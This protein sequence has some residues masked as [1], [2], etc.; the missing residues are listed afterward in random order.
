MRISPRF[1]LRIMLF[2]VAIAASASAIGARMKRD[3]EAT[4]RS[5]VFNATL[6]AKRELGDLSE[7][8]VTC[9]RSGHYRAQVVFRPKGEGTK[10][11]RSYCVDSCS[12]GMKMKVTSSALP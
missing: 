8:D 5:L 1:S 4:P 10:E 6:Q 3:D 9:Q 7:F 2:A 12:C 11:G